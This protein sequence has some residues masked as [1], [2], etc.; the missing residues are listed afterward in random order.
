[1]RHSRV[2]F[3]LTC[4]TILGRLW[5]LPVLYFRGCTRVSPCSFWSFEHTSLSLFYLKIHCRR[6]PSQKRVNWRASR[7]T[8]GA[9]YS[10]EVCCCRPGWEPGS[11]SC[12]PPGGTWRLS[13]VELSRVFG[14]RQV[15]CR[16]LVF[17]FFPVLSSF[18]EFCARVTSSLDQDSGPWV[19]SKISHLA[20]RCHFHVVVTSSCVHWSFRLNRTY[21][22]VSDI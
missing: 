1:M 18:P 13:S 17:L 15:N 11:L 2:I 21:C 3:V 16:N 20:S 7:V 4:I 5:C 22:L 9:A 12:G 6:C 19:V 14:R 10:C 8:S